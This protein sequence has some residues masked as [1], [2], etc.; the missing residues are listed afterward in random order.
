MGSAAK[1]NTIDPQVGLGGS[2]SCTET[3]FQ[4]T[5]LTQSFTGLQ[6]G[7]IN[8]FQN[9]INGSTVTLD[10]LVV[11]VTSSF[12]GTLTCVLLNGAP[13]NSATQS[14]SSSCTF[15]DATLLQSISPGQIYGLTFGPEF[16]STVDITLAQTVITPEPTTLLLLGSGFVALFA[17]RKRLTGTKK[18]AV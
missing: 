10:T 6:T 9:L 2:G 4:E 11:N 1:A 5:S 15:F 8:D 18:V 7:C 17:G 14:S 13:L 12:G 16:G 3:P